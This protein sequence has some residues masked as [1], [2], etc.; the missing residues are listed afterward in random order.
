LKL[1]L[2]IQSS[3]RRLIIAVFLG[4]KNL[5]VIPLLS[6]YLFLFSAF[7][8]MSS[9]TYNLEATSQNTRYTDFFL[10]FSDQDNDGK[11]SLEEMVSGTFSGMSGQG[12]GTFRTILTVPSTTADSPYTDG[13]KYPNGADRIYWTFFDTQGEIDTWVGVW[14]Y[15]VS[16]VPVP[17]SLLL[18]GTGLFGL[19]AAGWRRRQA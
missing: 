9:Q 19:G 10:Q 17:S 12:F 11:F 6:V 7:P 2:G 18:L 16:P 4:R 5:W 1:N 14:Q 8:A 3:F 13:P 15:D